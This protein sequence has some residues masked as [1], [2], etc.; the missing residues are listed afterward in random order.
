MFCLNIC[1]FSYFCA[2]DMFIKYALSNKLPRKRDTVQLVW[3][4]Q[5]IKVVPLDWFVHYNLVFT[6]RCLFM[7]RVYIF[8]LYYSLLFLI[9]FEIRSWDKFEDS[10][11]IMRFSNGDKCWNGPDRSLTVWSLPCSTFMH[12]CLRA[13]FSVICQTVTY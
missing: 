10:Y 7:I 13:P 6:R 3:G 5:Y 2:S 8:L 11:R 1:I 9:F 4:M 12:R